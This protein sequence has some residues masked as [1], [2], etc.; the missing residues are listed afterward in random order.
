MDNVFS[1]LS[2]PTN[3]LPR[4]L[5]GYR[6]KSI[7]RYVSQLIA[8]EDERS[9]S[10]Q[11][12]MQRVKLDLALT[13]ERKKNLDDRA[14]YLRLEC[15]RLRIQ[16]EREKMTA[17]YAEAGVRQEILRL[18]IDHN[19]RVQVIQADR[20]RSD[21]EIQHAEELLWNLS[22][23]LSRVL[24]EAQTI[25]NQQLSPE[26]PESVWKAFVQIV[27]G[28][29]HD[30]TTPELLGA[31]HLLRYA[32]PDGMVQVMTRQGQSLGIATAVIISR[33]PPTLVA[34]VVPPLGA[35]LTEDVQV[36]RYRNLM[37]R[38]HYQVVSESMLLE[39]LPSRSR[40]GEAVK[41]LASTKA[42]SISPTIGPA[43]KEAAIPQWHGGATEDQN[44]IDTAAPMVNMADEPSEPVD[45]VVAAPAPPDLDEYRPD[46]EPS[47]ILAHTASETFD[48]PAPADA[49]PM[50]QNGP[51]LQDTQSPPDAMEAVAALSERPGLDALPTERDP[52]EMPVETAPEPSH[53]LAPPSASKEPERG[54]PS[55]S[56]PDYGS[57]ESYADHAAN[58]TPKAPETEPDSSVTRAASEA[59]RGE[60]THVPEPLWSATMDTEVASDP[61]RALGLPGITEKAPPTLGSSHKASPDGVF[62]QEPLPGL[63]RSSVTLPPPI[64]TDGPSER[65]P[66]PAA[67]QPSPAAANPGMPAESGGLDVRT[68]LYGKRV[69]QDILDNQRNLIAR[70]GETI[71]P[72]L[73]A[74]VETAGQL[75]D[76]IVHMVF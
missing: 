16:L 33:I 1:P 4:G 32:L 29:S 57:Q 58:L 41:A 52:A 34:Y 54:A 13:Q 24:Q 14:Q 27:L 43:A 67:A 69:G 31:G 7:N 71:T 18:E 9:R 76:L 50:G 68:F 6:T 5:F 36:I 60:S 15:E 25:A 56:P 10:W 35:I 8:A 22:E 12:D 65:A 19:Q 64:W 53:V 3:D 55:D 30:K 17:R 47:P 61:G 45:E 72:E 20:S 39:A 46:W 37:V 42:P 44:L 40:S 62:D 66:K 2:D 48:R 70:A 38:Q 75:P 23:S 63:N 74:R 11:E 59:P 26:S 28:K 21:R 73:V 49:S 51:M